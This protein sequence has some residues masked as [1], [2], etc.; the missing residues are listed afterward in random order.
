MFADIFRQVGE[1]AEQVGGGTKGANFE[2]AVAA[3]V[4][5]EGFEPWMESRKLHHEERA[6]R[7]ID[8]GIV[9]GHTLY[10]IECKARVRGIRIDRGDWSARLNRQDTL[11]EGLDQARTLVEFLH[12]ERTGADYEV[13]RAVTDIEHVLCTPGPEFIWTRDPELWLTDEIPRICTAEELIL[14][15]TAA[16]VAA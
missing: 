2:A 9:A 12:E 13:P 8:L 5:E 16:N 3:R 11:A 7:E 6:E 15:L 14:V 10:V 1:V 4:R